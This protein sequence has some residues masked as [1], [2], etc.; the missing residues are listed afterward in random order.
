MH[1]PNSILLSLSCY[2]RARTLL[3]NDDDD[4]FT[5]GS[6]SKRKPGKKA[7]RKK[8][9]KSTPK[10]SKAKTLK[11]K[12]KTK[13]RRSSGDV[14]SSDSSSSSTTS[15]PKPKPKRRKKIS[16]NVGDMAGK[17]MKLDITKHTHKIN[18]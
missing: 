12:P 18:T 14:S 15:A 16:E 9:K 3:G 17:F 2:N 7:S 4:A 6:Q 5:V 13:R 8:A 11:V 1:P 10:T